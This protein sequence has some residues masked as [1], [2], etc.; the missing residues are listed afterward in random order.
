MRKPNAHNL[1]SRIGSSLRLW[2]GLGLLA[3]ICLLWSPFAWVLFA[4]NRGEKYQKIGRA[5]IRLGFAFY[6]T[7]LQKLGW[8]KL[9]IED[10]EWMTSCPPSIIAPNHPG[11]LDAVILLTL[12]PNATCIL[13][14]SL[15][16]HPLFGAGARL[17]GYIPNDRT[18]EMIRQAVKALNKGQHVLMFPEGTRT[19]KRPISPL[20]VSPFLIAWRSRA[21]IQTVLIQNPSGF[22]G[23]ESPLFTPPQ[24][25]IVMSIKPGRTYMP[26]KNVRFMAKVVEDYY[27]DTL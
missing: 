23:K 19:E 16:D 9:S 24:F 17:A 25:P 27:H 1:P 5:I 15:L 12:L 4:L 21:P 10:W 11:L 14:S 3:V 7:V 22:L 18:H 2:F 6:L 13:K 26:E 20:K 8:L